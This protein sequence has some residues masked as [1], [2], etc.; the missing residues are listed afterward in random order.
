MTIDNKILEDPLKAFDYL[1]ERVY[2]DKHP[3]SPKFIRKMRKV[4]EEEQE[5]TMKYTLL[6]GYLQMLEADTYIAV[7]VCRMQIVCEVEKYIE[8][9]EFVSKPGKKQF[10]R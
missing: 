8:Q 7:D 4:I 3:A 1:S 5:R 10:R 2:S 6:A 9:R